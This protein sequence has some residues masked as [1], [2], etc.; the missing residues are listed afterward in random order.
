MPTPT[1][2]PLANITLGSSASSVTFSSIPGTYRDLVLV[3]NGAISASAPARGAEL[4]FNADE[5]SSNYSQVGAYSDGTAASYTAANQ[6]FAIT[7]TQSTVFIQIMDYSATDKHKTT[8]FRYGAG[9]AE[10]GMVA[11]RWAST[12][13]ITSLSIKDASSGF[14]FNAGTTF[15]L[16]GIAS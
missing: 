5:T 9:A 12:S 1:Y 7:N 13:A 11:G 14:T 3:I 6:G 10:T 4:F 8:L 15:S 2:I 16:Y